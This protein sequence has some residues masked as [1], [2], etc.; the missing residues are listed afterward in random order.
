IM[1][2][3]EEEDGFLHKTSHH[4]GLLWA[5][6]NLAWLPKYLRDTS[7]ILLQ[8]SR[9]DPGGNLSNRPLNSITEIFKPWH[10][11]TLASY[12]ERMEVLKYITEQEKET[13]WSLLIRMLPEHHGVAHPTHKMRWRMFDKNTNLKYTYQEIWD[14]HSTVIEMLIN[15][16]DYDENKFAQLINETTNLKPKDRSRVLKWAD[17]VCS[18]VEQKN[19]STWA[20]IRKIL[21]RH[22]SHPDT[23][24]ALPESVLKRLEDLYNKLQPTSTLEKYIWLFN[25]HRPEFPEGLVYRSEERRVGKER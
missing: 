9:L 1:E 2:M 11:Q 24:W 15:L 8:L 14:T 12:D 17:E 20:A 21:N 4:T 25:D 3:F 19:F 22:R 16:F 18:K 10:Y 5:L 13:G 23:D 7:L 6:E